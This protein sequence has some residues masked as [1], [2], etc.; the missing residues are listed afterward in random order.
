[1][2][3]VE[4]SHWLFSQNVEEG[5]FVVDATVG[6]GH[7]TIFLAKL[8]GENGKVLGFDIQKKAIENTKKRLNSLNLSNIKLVHDGH[9]NLDKYIGENGSISGMLFNLGYL[10]SGDK[11]IITRPETTINALS[12][13]L[14]L[15]EP[16]GIIIIVVYVGHSGGEVEKEKLLNYT[17]QLDD[18]IYNVFHYSYIN[19][20]KRPPEVIAVRKRK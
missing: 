11:G 6:N 18:K 17:S 2:Q 7:D 5:A 13:G 1:M 8:V 9:E 4:Y 19:Q 3:G 14:E 15:L 16:G 20:Q 12:T 10:P